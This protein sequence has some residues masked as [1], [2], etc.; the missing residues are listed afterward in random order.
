MKAL[1]FDVRRYLYKQWN[2]RN[3]FSYVLIDNA[4]SS[5][6]WSENISSLY[7]INLV[8]GVPADEQLMFLQ[9][10]YPYQGD[11]P[12]I[13]EEVNFPTNK[14]ADIHIVPSRYNLCILLFDVTKTVLLHQELQ[15]KRNELKLLYEQEM[16]SIRTLKQSYQELKKQKEITEAAHRTRSE[17]LQHIT[18]DLKSPLNGILGF[19]Q[20]LEMLEHPLT[21]EALE[22]VQE[23]KNSGTYLL[24]MID[25]LLGI[26]EIESDHI[27]LNP[28]A[29]SV[30]TVVADSIGGLSAMAKK[31]RLDFIVRI[32]KSLPPLL[33]DLLC[34]QQLIVT[35]LSNAIKHNREYGCIIISAYVTSTDSLHLNIKD[36]GNGIASEDFHS[37]FLPHERHGFKS[38]EPQKN[39][40]NLR[41]CKRLTELM[42]G[43]IGVYSDVGIGSLFWLEFPLDKKVAQKNNLKTIL[44]IEDNQAYLFLMSCFIEQYHGCNLL[45]A[46]NTTDIFE[47][48]NNHSVSVILLD[49]DTFADTYLTIFQALQSYEKSKHIPVIALFNGETQPYEI[50]EALNAGF[51]D[52]LAKPLDFNLAMELFDRLTAIL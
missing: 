24:A 46:K 7:G 50:R 1:P 44:Y 43:S 37:L 25:R 15:Q 29:V 34:F 42:H 51:Y 38:V 33:I 40:S 18:R 27:H 20:L 12:F 36:T 35:L 26:S 4:D 23:I 6:E 39:G 14:A 52:Y 32:D 48:I 5:L 21:G 10:I 13:L 16:R 30:S 41:I 22:Y 45:N 3:F 17:L 2:K 11:Q 28:E 19:T 8:Q 47:Y 31:K 9:G 49:V